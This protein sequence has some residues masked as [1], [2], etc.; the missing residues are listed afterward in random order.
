VSVVGLTQIVFVLAMSVVLFDHPVNA[1][2]LVGTALVVAPT[3]W[4]LTRPR[5]ASA[6]PPDPRAAE[7]AAPPAGE[8]EP[9]IDART[10]PL[11]A[12]HLRP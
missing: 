4:L 3:A 1:V 10:P 9:A 12:P 2:T 8:V 11:A 5:G 6:T 7:P